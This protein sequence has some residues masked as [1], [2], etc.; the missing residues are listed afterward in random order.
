M[1]L[2]KIDI[3][4]ALLNGDRRS[5]AKLISIVEDR[6]EGAID[7]MKKLY[8]KAGKAWIIGVTGPAGVG[9]STLL[10]C[11]IREFRKE[12]KKIG[13]IAID[14]TSPFSGGAILADRIRMQLHSIDEGVFIRSMGTRGRLGGISHATSDVVDLLDA[15]GMDIVIIE[16]VGVGQDEVDIVKIAHS[17]IVVL[18]PGMGDEVQIMK[19]GLMEI[20]DV[21]VINKADKQGVEKLQAELEVLLSLAS[22]Q[23]DWVAKI[24]KTIASKSEGISNLVTFLKEHRDYL[25]R[26]SKLQMR[27]YQA[28]KQRFFDAYHELSL[29]KV[30]SKCSDM[31][32]EKILNNIYER[33]VDPY[34]AAELFLNK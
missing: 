7:I 15:F 14:P 13:V 10:D 28:V 31:D 11:L 33:K 8:H 32:L 9:K 24:V 18:M 34:T 6:D 1:T 29:A 12:G 23:N 4:I 5:L 20:A 19:A 21:F 26:S 3:D 17:I 22:C 16:T 30:V 25:S 2:G 27:K